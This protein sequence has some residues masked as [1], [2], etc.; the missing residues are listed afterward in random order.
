MSGIAIEIEI[1][2]ARPR[3]VSRGSSPAMG[4]GEPPISSHAQLGGTV[5]EAHDDL[6]AR[7][8]RLHQAVGIRDFLEPE[9]FNWLRL[10]RPFGDA[11]DDHLKWN[12][13]ERELQCAGDNRAGKDAEVYTARYLED[14]LQREPAAA[15]SERNVRL[16][17]SRL[18]EAVNN[19][20]VDP[21]TVTQ[22]VVSIWGHASFQR[23][24]HDDCVGPNLDFSAA[25][26]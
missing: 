14:R 11:I 26:R 12:F 23:A 15:L 19:R 7:L 21:F 10:V 13:R 18:E 3:V 17:L 9:D 6:A 20:G 4:I 22:V 1:A 24:R 5:L 8:V 2:G 16:H 25:I